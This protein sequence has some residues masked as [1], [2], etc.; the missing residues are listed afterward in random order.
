MVSESARKALGTFFAILAGLALV[1]FSLGFLDFPPAALPF[2]NIGISI[3]FVAVPI[4]ALFRAASFAW[5]WKHAAT[6]LV[7]G[8]SGQVLT[9][10]VLGEVQGPVGG[11]LSSL[12]NAFLACWCVGLGALLATLIRERNML[13]PIA[14]FLAML[15]IFLVLTPVGPTAKYVQQN[16]K[17]FSKIAYNVPKASTKEEKKSTQGKAAPGAFV[18]PA[19]WIFLSMFFIALFKF[20]LRTK[21]TSRAMV[22]TLVGYLLLVLLFGSIK[23]GS[24]SLGALPALLPIGACVLIVNFREF[25]LAKDEVYGTL[26][27]C[28][29]GIGLIAWG[30]TRKP[31]PPEP[32]KPLETS[33]TKTD[34]PIRQ[35]APQPVPARP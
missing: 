2:I 35:P 22:P 24:I 6:F 29:I 10:F 33:S 13:L 23:I 26:F 16:P 3:L 28:A 30:A 7:V 5:N 8:V 19:D 20:G 25:K 18:G 11:V 17:T 14:L 34:S 1:Q 15:D 12:G 32:T 21:E 9:R 4:L 27:I 31:S